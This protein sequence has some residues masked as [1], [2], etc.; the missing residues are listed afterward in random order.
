[1]KENANSR[2]IKKNK[3]INLSCFIRQALW[4]LLISI[5]FTVIVLA[6][7]TFI[8]Y[9]AKNEKF[10]NDSKTERTQSLEE[11]KDNILNCPRRVDKVMLFI[12][13]NLGYFLK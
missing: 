11:E 6:M 9:H 2:K 10:L 8:P 5:L 7:D 12:I 13:D 1:M 4:I 3:K